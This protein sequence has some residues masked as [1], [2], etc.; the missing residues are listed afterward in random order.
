VWVSKREGTFVTGSGSISKIQGEGVGSGRIVRLDTEGNRDLRDFEE[1]SGENKKGSIF[2]C[3]SNGL[4]ED[5]KADQSNGHF[6]AT[7]YVAAAL[8]RTYQNR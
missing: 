6:H 1:E 7:I 8:Q 3:N 2:G 5:V 4:D